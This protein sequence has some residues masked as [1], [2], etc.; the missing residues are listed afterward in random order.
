MTTAAAVR[1]QQAVPHG[2]SS[3]SAS[4][5]VQAASV[6]STTLRGLCLLQDPANDKFRRIKLSNAKFSQTVGGVPGSL[7][8][9]QLLGF[10]PVS[11]GG[12]QLLVMPES[13]ATVPALQAAGAELTNAC[14]NPF[15]GV[16]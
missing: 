9:L 4:S 5:S 12:E 11:E 15:F 13:K 7:D 10:E 6:Q 1:Q 2:L 14:T 3:K 8:F 16:L